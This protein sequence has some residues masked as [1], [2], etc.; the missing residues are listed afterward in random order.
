MQSQ[1]EGDCAFSLLRV[2]LAFNGLVVSASPRDSSTPL[3]SFISQTLKLLR[4]D[5]ESGEG[6]AHGAAVVSPVYHRMEDVVRCRDGAEAGLCAGGYAETAEEALAHCEG[7]PACASSSGSSSGSSSSGSSS[8]MHAW[9]CLLAAKCLMC[10]YAQYNDAVSFAKRGLKHLNL[11][12]PL[13]S[14]SPANLLVRFEAMFLIGEL[15]EQLGEV[16]RA[17]PYLADA[18]SVSASAGAGEASPA[19]PPSLPSSF[20]GAVYSTHILR[21]WHRLGS[22]RFEEVCEMLAR[23]AAPD[24][25]AAA[26]GA[27][28]AGGREWAAGV[29][30]EAGRLAVSA[31]R[32]S[33]GGSGAGQRVT[34]YRHIWWQFDFL[35]KPNGGGALFHTSLGAGLRGRLHRALSNTDS[36][37]NSNNSNSDSDGDE[38]YGSLD[39]LGALGV[40]CMDSFDAS[41]AVRRR[42]AHAA[43]LGGEPSFAPFYFASTSCS[44]SVRPAREAMVPAPVPASGAGAGGR[45]GEKATRSHAISVMDASLLGAGRRAPLDQVQNLLIEML[46]NFETGA[47]GA[48][49][50]NSSAA[51]AKYSS[52]ANSDPLS[53]DV[54]V[55][56]IATEESRG[57]LLV[58]RYDRLF[59][60][61]SV[62]VPLG[63]ALGPAGLPRRW[64]ALTEGNVQQLTATLGPESAGWGA[65]QK[66]EWWEARGR[67]D[68]DM[69]A[70]SRDLLSAGLGAWRCLLSD[71][72][73]PTPAAAM[74][75]PGQTPAS[76]LLK[77]VANANAAID[78]SD[79]K[80]LLNGTA[81]TANATHTGNSKA[82]GGRQKAQKG[83]SAAAEQP[84]AQ[85][86]DRVEP[87]LRL[88]LCSL[89][90]TFLAASPLSV[91]ECRAVAA[92][93]LGR[94]QDTPG[95]G[96]EAEAMPCPRLDPPGETG[97]AGGGDADLL[98]LVDALI[99]DFTRLQTESGA[100]PPPQTETPLAAAPAPAP[101][102]APVDRAYAAMSVVEL[103]A[104]L[105]GAALP[106]GGKKAD[107]IARLQ[108]A[109][110]PGRERSSSPAVDGQSSS[111]SSSSSSST[112]SSSSSSSQRVAKSHTILIL[113]EGL[114]GMPWENTPALCGRGCSRVP[115]LAVLC[116]LAAPP[117]RD[118]RA[119]GRGSRGGASD[120]G[121]GGVATVQDV[122][123][124]A[125]LLGDLDIQHPVDASLSAEGSD[126]SD[127][128]EPKLS[129]RNQTATSAKMKEQLGGIDKENVTSSR[130][131]KSSSSSSGQAASCWF[132]I[133]PEGNLPRTRETMSAFLLPLAERYRWTGVIA[134]TPPENVVRWVR[135]DLQHSIDC[136]IGLITIL[137]YLHLHIHIHV[138]V[139]V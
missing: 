103:K 118:S 64:A 83:E 40:Q 93:V 88:L 17:L 67:L 72:A 129:K 70:F 95:G 104:A 99:A 61:L 38:A 124:L 126:A 59:G 68:A 46:S 14:L 10:V 69:L 22:A 23:T 108:E 139:H 16:E 3:N 6:G 133:D 19:S 135:L 130:G 71:T 33:G 29:L 78:A 73:T 85:S 96:R 65:A 52:E 45:A 86:F 100:D 128:E 36:N 8:G 125:K 91:D 107:L 105:K 75:A 120:G 132:C 80:S 62:S 121:G 15:Y 110:P 123:G 57:R 5:A 113:D 30:G 39:G 137:I 112:S 13:H 58:S 84:A 54:A 115:N 55:I 26:M 111:S 48:I 24:T 77:V 79:L 35:G 134:E 21:V 44:P 56:C 63:E 97:S 98:P 4:L 9:V 114:Q 122:E 7:E 32:G 127:T 12:T 2:Q 81:S 42:M 27:E 116:A 89:D 119:R 90:A 47:T 1:D 25:A 117:G 34:S 94:A 51:H 50:I 101:A 136:C 37:T 31:L 131:T 11:N 28:Q 92:R 53:L 82:R 87:W 41:R 106:L 60:P 109:R 66:R 20:L 138:H 102:P 18:R 49:D 43:M 76:A 74:S